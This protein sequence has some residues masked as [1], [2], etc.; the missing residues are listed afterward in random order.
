MNSLRHLNQDKNENISK[1]DWRVVDDWNLLDARGS[2]WL[3]E[4]Q[5]ETDTSWDLASSK[6]LFT[7]QSDY[8]SEFWDPELFEPRDLVIHSA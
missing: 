7:G 4:K 1:K 3:W 6:V 5:D 2:L 8:V